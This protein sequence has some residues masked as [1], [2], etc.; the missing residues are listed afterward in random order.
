MK[1]SVKVK[2]M[3]E[4]LKEDKFKI[5]HPKGLTIH[6]GPFSLSHLMRK[7]YQ[8]CLETIENNREVKKN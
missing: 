3:V 7:G 4:S 1:K 6:E 2:K 8:E 5:I